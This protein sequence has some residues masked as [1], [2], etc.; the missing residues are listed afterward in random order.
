MENVFCKGC[1]HFY[2]RMAHKGTFCEHPN[3]LTMKHDWHTEWKSYIRQPSKIN[4]N[5]N[6]KWFERE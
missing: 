1:K 6:C 3:N 5:N 2:S 4:K